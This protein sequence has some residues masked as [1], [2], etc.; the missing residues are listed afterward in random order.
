MVSRSIASRRR[1]GPAVQNRPT[2]QDGDGFRTGVRPPIPTTARILSRTTPLP[3]RRATLR[4]TPKPAAQATPPPPTAQLLPASR[5]APKHPNHPTVAGRHRPD[6]EASSLL[7]GRRL[8]EH[9]APCGDKGHVANVLCA[10]QNISI[11]SIIDVTKSY[12]SCILNL[13]TAGHAPL[14][15]LLPRSRN[16]SGREIRPCRSIC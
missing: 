2:G 11:H 3:S 10:C 5:T 13:Q 6:A 12:S 14:R 9:A 16:V 7:A 4:K 8:H 1:S 15:S